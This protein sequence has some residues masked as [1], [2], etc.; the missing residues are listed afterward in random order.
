MNIQL[1]VFIVSGCIF[2]RMIYLWKKERLRSNE[3]GILL[4]V[5]ISSFFE[6]IVRFMNLQS[7]KYKGIAAAACIIIYAFI[8][9]FIKRKKS[10]FS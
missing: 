8:M 3:F 5:G 6:L 1:I 10:Y 7:P 9:Y 4:F 2:L